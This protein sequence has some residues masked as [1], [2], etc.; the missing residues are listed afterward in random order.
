MAEQM[1]NVTFR[2]MHKQNEITA[3]LVSQIQQEILTMLRSTKYIISVDTGEL[4]IDS[5]DF[6]GQGYADINVCIKEKN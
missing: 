5:I 1:R 3:L 6:R 2:E 4:G